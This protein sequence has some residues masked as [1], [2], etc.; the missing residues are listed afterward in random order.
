MLWMPSSGHQPAS[1]GRRVNGRFKARN[2]PVHL[3]FSQPAL[4]ALE[5]RP[6]GGTIR[7]LTSETLMRLIIPIA[8]LTFLLSAPVQAEGWDEHA[9]PDAGF[10][11]QFPVAPQVEAGSYET[12]GGVRRSRDSVFGEARKQRVH[13]NGG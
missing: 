7:A 4:S 13:G 12:V 6:I 8:A 11:V 1:Y 9:Y 2:P 3:P 5:G 10:A